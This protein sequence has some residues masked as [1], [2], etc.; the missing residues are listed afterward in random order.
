[1]HSVN[2][3]E[4]Q[5]LRD[6]VGAVEETSGGRLA[7]WLQPESVVDPAKCQLLLP[8][9]FSNRVSLSSFQRGLASSAATPKTNASEGTGP[10]S[11]SDLV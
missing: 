10:K 1:M 8:G 4:R 5:F 11:K 3:K 2:G 7:R 9:I 6:F